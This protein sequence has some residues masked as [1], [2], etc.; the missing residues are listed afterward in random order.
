MQC[1]IL[2]CA[3]SVLWVT[4]GYTLVFGAGGIDGW[5]GGLDKVF[6]RTVTVDALSG[7][8]SESVFIVFQL[9]FAAITVGGFA[10]RMNFAA[11]LIFCPSLP[12]SF[13]WTT[14][15]AASIP[16]GLASPAKCSWI[17]VEYVGLR[18]EL[19]A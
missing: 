10:E 16:W 17:G 12:A 11:M 6:L 19:L 15:S 5:I 13:R 9:T 7:T 8:I 14:F 2:V 18:C 4:L 1:F 3:V